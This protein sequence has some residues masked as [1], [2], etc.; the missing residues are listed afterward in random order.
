MTT[1]RAAAIEMK[2]QQVD[3]LQAVDQKRCVLRVACWA[4]A[5]GRLS[6]VQLARL[7]VLTWPYPCALEDVC[8]AIQRRLDERQQQ[9][10]E[11][12]RKQKVSAAPA[13]V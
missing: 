1:E 3:R 10:R 6:W 5:L 9:Q 12:D 2:M 13:D 7:A 4:Y 11:Q 8:A